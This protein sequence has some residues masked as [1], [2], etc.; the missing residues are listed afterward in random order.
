MAQAPYPQLS[1]FRTEQVLAAYLGL[2]RAEI[3]RL[4]R[5]ESVRLCPL[6][7]IQEIILECQAVS[8]CAALGAPTFLE[9]SC[10]LAIVCPWLQTWSG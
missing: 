10:V 2:H 1:S 6:I 7:V 9:H 5:T 4:T 8:L 3:G